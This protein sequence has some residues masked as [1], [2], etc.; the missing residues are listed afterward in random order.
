V[1]PSALCSLLRAAGR[2]VGE[3]GDDDDA[4]FDSSSAAVADADW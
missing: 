3:L 2:L 1:K 4:P